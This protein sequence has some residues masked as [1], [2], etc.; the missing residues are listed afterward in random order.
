M[1]GIGA[2]EISRAVEKIYPA[3]PSPTL[4]WWTMVF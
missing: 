2:F 4:Y 3:S 1:P